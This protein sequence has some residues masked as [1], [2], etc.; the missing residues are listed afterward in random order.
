MPGTLVGMGLKKLRTIGD[1]LGFG[2]SV[3]MCVMPPSR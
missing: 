3:S 1:A 2:S